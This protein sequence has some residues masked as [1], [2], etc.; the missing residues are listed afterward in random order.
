VSAAAR[1]AFPPLARFCWCG[2]GPP[3]APLP[4]PSTRACS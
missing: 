1:R 2:R 3:P 4:L